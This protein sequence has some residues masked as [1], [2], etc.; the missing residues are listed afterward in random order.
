M[1][2]E[3]IKEK[4]EQWR[5]EGKL[6]A[7]SEFGE[8]KGLY[9]RILKATDEG[10][11]VKASISKFLLH[12]DIAEEFEALVDN[13][14][15]S[16]PYVYQK[17]NNIG[18]YGEWDR[19]KNGV[20]LKYRQGRTTVILTDS[21]NTQQVYNDISCEPKMQ[22]VN[23]IAH[24]DTIDEILEDTELELNDLPKTILTISFS[25]KEEAELQFEN[26]ALYMERNEIDYSNCNLI[27]QFLP[28]RKNL[29]HHLIHNVVPTIKQ[30][31]VL[32]VSELSC[33]G[34]KLS[35]IIAIIESCTV[36]N[37]TIVLCK[38]DTVIDV[39]SPIG[40]AILSTLGLAE[41]FKSDITR[42]STKS[43]LDTIKAKLARGEVHISKTGNVVTHLGNTG[44]PDRACTEAAA[45]KRTEDREEWYKAS[46]LVEQVR[47]MMAEG[48]HYMD[49]VAKCGELYDKSP[50]VYCTR[51]GGRLTRS[52]FYR[53]KNW[54]ETGSM[55]GKQNK[56]FDT[57]KEVEASDI[58]QLK[59]IEIHADETYSILSEIDEEDL[60]IDI[61][62]QYNDNSIKEI[63]QMLLSKE[64]WQRSEVE[65]LCRERGQM[66][67][68]VLE[69]INN[70]SYSVVY[71]AVVEDEDDII[72]VSIEYKDKLC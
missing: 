68:Y 31:S 63:M 67:G 4:L 21:D 36:R 2:K 7:Y 43:S 71:D 57:T 44:T 33:L 15:I 25:A 72:N 66:L 53:V 23:N 47:L 52:L 61:T 59:E 41:K 6:I 1:T 11:I 30:D 64:S 37:I 24:N 16:L 10:T 3:Q 28:S 60:D 48:V 35:D 56:V 13:G 5:D 70:Y 22:V 65:E 62:P 51:G 27:G 39:N 45:R 49:I 42:K 32:Y 8:T 17:R 54:I 55:D 12:P 20:I 29:N 18:F 26:I 69:E 14:Q 46:P 50:E 58:E 38:D 40:K 19:V 9:Y 34:D